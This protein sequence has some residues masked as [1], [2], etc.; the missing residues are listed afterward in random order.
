MIFAYIDPSGSALIVQWLISLIV[1]SY[2]YGK[3]GLG[4]VQS[5]VPRELRA[6]A[7]GWLIASSFANIALFRFWTEF[8]GYPDSARFEMKSAA[9]ATLY[10]AVIVDLVLITILVWVIVRLSSCRNT[11]G[12]ISSVV[13]LALCAI[14]LNAVRAVFGD[15]GHPLLRSGAILA[16]GPARVI[17]V[18]Y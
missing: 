6:G 16:F 9:N 10:A 2:I 5:V 15:E 7:S 14:P 13:L 12:W 3:R 18:R 8:F 17:L 4:W 11:I 1:G